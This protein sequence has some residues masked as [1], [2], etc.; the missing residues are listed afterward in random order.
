MKENRFFLRGARGFFIR[1]V[2]MVLAICAMVISVNYQFPEHPACQGRLGAGFPVLYICDNWGGGS[3]AN[4]W[5]K[6]TP[7]DVINGGINLGG[8]LV[9]FLFYT[10]LFYI[11]IILMR[12]IYQRLTATRMLM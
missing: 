4:S 8:F 10:V 2:S 7:I 3:P 11:A 5:G 6:I 12:A 1:L 9:D